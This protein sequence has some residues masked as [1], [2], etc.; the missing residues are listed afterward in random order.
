MVFLSVI[1]GIALRW[2][3]GFTGKPCAF[4]LVVAAISFGVVLFVA[5]SAV[6]VRH[7]K[8]CSLLMQGMAIGV[9]GVGSLIVLLGIELAVRI[10]QLRGP[11]PGPDN[12]VLAMLAFAAIGILAQWLSGLADSL[13]PSGLSKGAL[14]LLYGSRLSQRTPGES[15]EYKHAYEALFNENTSDAQGEISG[16]G[17]SAITRR[18]RLI[19]PAVRLQDE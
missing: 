1:A 3:S 8:L 6:G 15:A 13:S 7:P 4:A 11:S 5:V 9:L 14:H 12:E 2:L 18:L 19:A 10:L 16:W 17:Y